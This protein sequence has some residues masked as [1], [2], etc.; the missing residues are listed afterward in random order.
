M[1]RFCLALLFLL[2]A[3]PAF[4]GFEEGKKAYDAKDWR[5]TIFNLRPLAETGDPRA[6]LVLGNMYAEGLG[7]EK[8]EKEAFSLYRAAAQLN[9]PEGMIAV[10]TFYQK[11]FGVPVNTKLA[12]EWF[13][14]AARLGSQTGAFFY[15]IHLYQGAR[16]AHYDIKPD[17]V[18]SLKWLRIAARSDEDKAIKK[19]AAAMGLTLATRLKPGQIEQAEKEAEAWK[20]EDPSKLGPFPDETAPKSPP[21]PRSP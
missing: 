11:G 8:D 6:M 19:A 9:D 2:A 18:Q 12:I 16:G 21:P 3:F 15:A 4:A 17:N 13:S 20:P 14:R 5:T 1:L 10:A 7:V